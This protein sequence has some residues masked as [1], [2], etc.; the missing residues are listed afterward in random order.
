[1]GAALTLRARDTRTGLWVS[2][3]VFPLA[4]QQ[5]DHKALI[6]PLR[7]D[8]EAQMDKGMALLQTSESHPDTRQN[9]L[10]IYENCDTLKVIA[11]CHPAGIPVEIHLDKVTGQFISYGL[12]CAPLLTAGPAPQLWRAPI[13]NDMYIKRQWLDTYYLPQARHYCESVTWTQAH[14]QHP[15]LTVTVEG[16]LGAP[17][18]AWHFATT[19]TYQIHATGH[20]HCDFKFKLCDPHRQLRTQLPRIG[21]SFKYL[22]TPTQVG[23]EG[24]GPHEN[25]PDS[26]ESAYLNWHEIHPEALF[27]NYP[28]PQENGARGGLR[29]L[30]IEDQHSTA[31]QRLLVYWP[32]EGRFSFR[33]Y[34]DAAIEAATHQHQLS[35]GYYYLNLDY[36]VNGL[37]SNSCG[38]EPSVAHQL[39]PGDFHFAYTLW[40]EP[41]A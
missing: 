2:Q 13:D 29:M 39:K 15:M 1:M 26:Q 9:P 38:P 4:P 31:P 23:Y 21:T 20:I 34:S 14:N 8:F 3:G 30:S 27:T 40:V 19:T 7:R 17:N 28:F 18:Q 35:Q 37:G 16:I 41:L 25:Y 5:K 6:S 24:L 36:K 12:E 10:N 32:K 11:N 33:P 22:Q